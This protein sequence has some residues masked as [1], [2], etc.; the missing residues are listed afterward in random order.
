MKVK[1]SGFTLIEIIIV[2]TLTVVVIGIASS[3]FITGNRVFSD[4]DVKTTLQMEAND[5][6]ET[7]SYFCMNASYIDSC[8]IDSN[9]IKD[10]KYNGNYL[11]DKFIN[12]SGEIEV[13]KKWLQI[14]RLKLKSVTEDSDNDDISNL[15]QVEIVY[16]NDKEILKIGSKTSINNVKSF[17]IQP[18]NLQDGNNTIL[19]SNGIKF[20]IVLNKNKMGKDL[21]YTI[22]FTVYFRNR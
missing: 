21:D 4:S 10:E 16:D 7:I 19:G 8:I 14:S 1:K 18:L 20:N 6:Q 17:N 22:N 5:I 12:I 9:E 2:I 13:D 11:K 15:N 3:I